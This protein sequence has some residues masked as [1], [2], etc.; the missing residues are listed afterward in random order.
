VGRLTVV[1]SDEAEATLERVARE[2]WPGVRGGRTAA[3]HWG[4]AMLAEV[5]TAPAA[6][7]AP[8]AGEALEAWRAAGAPAVHTGT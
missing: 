8:T 1:L 5:M 3:V 4:I 7:A 2:R 6:R